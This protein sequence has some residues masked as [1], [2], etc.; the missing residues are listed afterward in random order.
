MR[1]NSR[2]A[3]VKQLPD[4][5]IKAA[6]SDTAPT[7]DDLFGMNCNDTPVVREI[8]EEVLVSLR[9]EKQLKLVTED[10]KERPK[11]KTVEWSDRIVLPEQRTF[12]QMPGFGRGLK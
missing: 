1:R 6:D 10:G 5:I 12:F 8:L 4:L 3:L 9:D 11:T 7:L 2:A